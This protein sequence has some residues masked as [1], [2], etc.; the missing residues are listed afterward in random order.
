VF[1]RADAWASFWEKAMAPISRKLSKVPPVDFSQEMVVGVFRGKMPYPNYQIEI[2]SIRP[3]NHPDT[4][5]ALVVR[6]RDVTN[7]MGVFN[8]P[9]AVQPFHLKK[10]PA[11]PGEVVFIKVKR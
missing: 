7:M 11:V 4:G 3:E 2:R 8:P 5:E 6:Y 9:F 1:R 10:V